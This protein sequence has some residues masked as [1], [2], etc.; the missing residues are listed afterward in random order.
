MP[1]IP[2]LPPGWA[3]LQC[4]MARTA[5][6]IMAAPRAIHQLAGCRS[7]LRSSARPRATL[8]TAA[9]RPRTLGRAPPKLLRQFATESGAVTQYATP[10]KYLHWGMGGGV[11]AALALTWVAKYADPEMKATLMGLHESIGLLVIGQ[12]TSSPPPP[13]A[14]R[15]G[16]VQPRLVPH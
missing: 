16:H 10:L 14:T 12:A 15:R 4:L 6:P 7:V 13:R 3:R 1:F 5:A 2:G 11:I 8:R 9:P